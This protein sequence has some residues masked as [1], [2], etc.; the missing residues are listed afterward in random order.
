M[1]HSPVQVKR[2]K[3]KDTEMVPYLYH[4]MN[5]PLSPDRYHSKKLA[6]HKRDCIKGCGQLKSNTS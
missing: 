3:E 2:Y 6:G 1:D 4:V 5:I